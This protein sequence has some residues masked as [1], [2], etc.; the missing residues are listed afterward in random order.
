MYKDTVQQFFNARKI[1]ANVVSENAQPPYFQLKVALGPKGTVSKIENSIR[2]LSLALC[3]DSG[4]PFVYCSNGH[5][6]IEFMQGQHPVQSFESLLS[7]YDVK[8]LCKKYT[9]PLVCGT[10]KIMNNF[11]IDLAKLPHMLVSGLTGS[12]KSVFLHSV[13]QSLAWQSAHNGVSLVLMDPKRVEF[14]SYEK[15]SCL[16]TPVA[17]SV[18]ESVQNM[19]TLCALMEKRLSLLQKNGCVNLAE[20]RKKFP[21]K[22]ADYVVVVIDE[23]QSLIKIAAFEKS[24]ASLAA[25][26]RAAGISIIVATQYPHSRV[27]NSTITTHFD[28]RIVFRLQ[29]AAQSRCVLNTQGAENLQGKGD[30]LFSMGGEEILRFHGAF[31][32]P[33][34]FFVSQ[35]FKKTGVQKTTSFLGKVGSFFS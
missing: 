21:E 25:K 18:E 35:F 20:Y 1:D 8:E 26:G 30:G 5:V 9:L 11:I 24:L 28:G 2:E 34:S 17:F 19:Q 23:L 29:N 32:H 7:S 14:V 16:M 13:I 22:N 6:C 33:N 31:A 3:L 10:T 12:G 27:V 15:L 4:A